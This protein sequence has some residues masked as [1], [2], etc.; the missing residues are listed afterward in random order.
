MQLFD[1]LNIETQSDCNR[2]C[3]TCMRQNWPMPERLERHQMP[4]ELVFS[5]IDQ[6]E[7]MG[8]SNR[9][10]LQHFNE[11]LLDERIAEFGRYAKGRFSQVWL[12]TNGD[13]LTEGL[14]S[15]LDGSFDH[16][17]VALYGS[18][19]LQRSVKY[20]E[21]FKKTLITFSGGEHLVTHNSP[22]ARLDILITSAR[23]KP[24]GYESQA[25][26]I[27]GYDG[28]MMLCCDDIAASFDLGNARAVSLSEL[29]FGDTHREVLEVLSHPG[30]REN[31][32]LCRNCPRESA[33]YWRAV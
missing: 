26:C 12:N 17:H 25:R 3:E 14:A 7:E 23:G 15:E 21:W 6:A 13:T 33:P 30:G 19:K 22:D 9:V 16:L 5:L 29:W 2:R 24:C 32:E 28:K 27:I 11:P 20:R 18:N 8:F 31:Y 10:C 4:T 1:E